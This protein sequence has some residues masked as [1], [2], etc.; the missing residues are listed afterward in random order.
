MNTWRNVVA[1]LALACLPVAARADR[2]FVANLSGAWEVPPNAST[3]RAFGRVTLNGAENQITVSLFFFDLGTNQTNAH[4]HGP[5]APGANGP[6]LFT[7]G[8]TGTTSATFTALMFPV[9][10]PQVADL[11][12][13]LWYFNV[14]S[15][16]FP[17]GEIRGQI[18]RDTPFEAL[19][20]SDE[21]VPS[22]ASPA[23]G[24][25]RASLNQA[26]DLMYVTLSY[27]N[28]M[29]TQTA[30]HIHGPAAVGANA[31]VVFGIGAP[32]GTSGQITDLLVSPTTQQVAD[33]KAGL[34]YFNVH[35]TAFPGG[36]IRGQILPAPFDAPLSGA[37]EVPPNASTAT[38]FFRAALN[39]TE[40]RIV[41][42]VAYDALSSSLTGAHVHGP[43]APGS[44]APVICALGLPGGTSGFAE[45]LV[46]PATP[47]DAAN[48]K[49]G[50]LYVNVHSGVFPGGEIRGQIDMVFRNGFE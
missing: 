14:H 5:A 17:G 44:T 23:V 35:S 8:A 27:A 48:F 22:N 41:L 36:E 20:T 10:A 18:F 9:T 33:L 46:C 28:L 50:L 25:G 31:G 6:V 26:Q 13:G 40:T 3:A 12:A 7:L 37:Q 1:T 29:G 4:I 43:A 16:G 15:T 45:N 30:S 34:H 11:K 38:G 32:G 2:A 21:E 49:A 19:L 24:F 42:T 39:A 47:T